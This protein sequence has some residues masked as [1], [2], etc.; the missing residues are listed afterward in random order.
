MH[1]YT[2]RG[3]RAIQFRSNS[4]GQPTHD[5]PCTEEDIAKGRVDN[6]HWKGP[7]MNGPAGWYTTVAGEVPT[8]LQQNGLDGEDTSQQYVDALRDHSNGIISYEE[9]L[10]RRSQKKII[11]GLDKIRE[12]EYALWKAKREA[13]GITAPKKKVRRD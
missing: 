7:M 10:Y 12:T 3:W 8:L 4:I 9:S 6:Y 1:M 2:A 5:V 13:E 11:P